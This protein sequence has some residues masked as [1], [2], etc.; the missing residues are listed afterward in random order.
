MLSESESNEKIPNKRR[1]GVVRPKTYKRNIIKKS[2]TQRK[3]YINYKNKTIYQK[4]PH[5]IK[6]KCPA[7]CFKLIIKEVLSDIWTTFYSIEKKKS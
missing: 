1:E 5:E 3:E 4:T 6:C 2:R 7:K